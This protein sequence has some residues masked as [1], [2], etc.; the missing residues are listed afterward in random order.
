LRED[1]ER[2]RARRA[3][4]GLG[5]PAA[6]ALGGAAGLLLAHWALGAIVAFG[7]DLIP[8]VAEISIDPTALASR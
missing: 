1:D 7:M 3:S 4:A 2:S 6:A 5:K 8:R